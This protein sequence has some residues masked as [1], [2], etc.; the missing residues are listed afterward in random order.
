MAEVTRA[1]EAA[2]AVGEH[3]PDV[4]VMDWSLPDADGIAGTRQV[5][6]RFPDVTVVALTSTTDPGVA[7]GFQE[8][9]AAELFDKADLDGLVAWLTGRRDLS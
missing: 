7:R 6:A 9:G 4:V 2:H 5:K 3:D 1:G 8:A